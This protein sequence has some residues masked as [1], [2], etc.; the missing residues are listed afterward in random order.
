MPRGLAPIVLA[1]GA[2][3]GLAVGLSVVVIAWHYPSD[4]IGGILVAAGWG[5][6]V[7]AALTGRLAARAAR[8][9]AQ[10]SRPAAISVK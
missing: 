9:R 10:R 2:A 8:R 7:L 1:L 4:V 3:F 5:F 6:A